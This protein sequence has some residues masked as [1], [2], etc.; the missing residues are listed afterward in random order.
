[1]AEK[2]QK[3]DKALASYEK[4][5]KLDPTYLPALEGLGHLLVEHQRYGEALKAYQTI[6]LHH[7]EELTDLEVVEIYWQLGEIHEALKQKD[8]AQTNFEKALAIDPGHDPSL[9]ALIR[10]ADAAGRWDA[11]AEYRESL[12]SVLE[13]EAKFQS[14]LELA[15]LVCDK[16]SDPYRAID[17]YQV[18][19][20]LRPDSLEVMDSLYVLLR[21]TKQSQKAVEILEKMLGE[22]SIQKSPKLKKVWFAVGEISRDELKDMDRAVKAFNAA[23]DADHRFVEAFSALEQLLGSQKQ[24]KLL[25]ENYARMI[26]RVPKSPDT[27]AARMT[28]WR[29]LGDLYRQVLKEEDGALMAYQVVAAGLPD[30]GAV[31]EVYAE[32]ASR[33]PG[34]EAK[35]LEAWRRALPSSSDPGKVV[36][37]LSALQA[38]RKEY[39]Q[40]WL[41]AQ[42]AHGFIGQVGEAEQEILTKLGP[43]AK[44]REQ[45]THSLT[46]RQ[47]RTHLFHPKVRG[48]LTDAMALLF[49]QVG[50]HF[51]LPHSQY[52]INPKRH[53]IDVTT[54]Q[55][56]QVHQY[57]YVARLLGMEA[58][59]LY[60]PY[61][62]ATL[63]RV[64]KRSNEPAPEPLVG[65]EICHTHPVC[66]KVGGKFF[67]REHSEQSQKELLYQLGR[68]FA[69]VR[70]ELALSQRLS[71]DKLDALLQAAV[72]LSVPG[73]P[74]TAD[75]KMLEDMRR[76]L[77][78]GLTPQ[79]RTALAREIAAWLPQSSTEDLTS[80]LEGAELT[81]VR[82]GLFVANEA[83][84]VKRMVLGETGTAFR[85]PPRTK[86]RELMV[87]ALSED[88]HAL[89]VVVGTNVEVA[90]RAA[91]A[92]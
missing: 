33:K 11:S 90:P 31:Q 43:Y 91:A 74:F 15:T 62:V 19:H 82:T 88:L 1:V 65:I 39:D 89:R 22:P 60:S 67:P 73:F 46:D 34:H 20:R 92:R 53:R 49:E 86:V 63:E 83:E 59:E 12:V 32:L 81:A 29:A 45:A 76:L 36:S 75:R 44:K 16:L 18:A 3:K 17:A 41:A 55:V 40:A 80:Y 54:A 79:A 85:V 5:Y 58:V 47:W 30:D 38:K 21:E 8:Q 51:A 4:A 35:A 87:F 71:P 7:R 50:H 14:A 24:W 69:L 25:E 64:Q 84:P 2:L 57:R 10:I 28:L 52:Q 9:K 70:P 56:L 26:Q 68:T 37:A 77:E 48:H 42:V 23:L 13:G 61:L 72:S 78:R 6:L 66:L 27:H